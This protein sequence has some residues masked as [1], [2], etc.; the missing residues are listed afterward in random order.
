MAKTSLIWGAGAVLAGYGTPGSAGSFVGEQP[1]FFMSYPVL[2]VDGCLSHW[3]ML[4]PR[5]PRSLFLSVDL[6]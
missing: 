3:P 4:I 5:E 1:L 2:D 6:P